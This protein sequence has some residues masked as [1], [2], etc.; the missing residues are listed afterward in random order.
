ML[1]KQ[2][3][4]GA[5]CAEAD[6]TPPPKWNRDAG[7]PRKHQNTVISL[8]FDAEK[9]PN[10]GC[11]A[12]RNSNI[13]FLR[14]TMPPPN[15][16]FHAGSESW[17]QRATSSTRSRS[18]LSPLFRIKLYLDRYYLMLSAFEK[19]Y[20]D[21]LTSPCNLRALR[22]HFLQGLIQDSNNTLNLG[23]SHCA[24]RRHEHTTWQL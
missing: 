10:L 4:I 9:I 5:Q 18:T 8:G 24:S 2:L 13:L 20:G 12:M 16:G 23:S 6:A 14:E 3:L 19:A 11:P 21:G 17:M 1:V 7:L 15:N 22:N